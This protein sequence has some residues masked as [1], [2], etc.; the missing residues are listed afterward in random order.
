M[1]YNILKFKLIGI[2]GFLWSAKWSQSH[3]MYAPTSTAI[4][5]NI[6]HD[7]LVQFEMLNNLKTQITL[8]KLQAHL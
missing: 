8:E 7:T 4:F 2:Q 5:S 3:F 1:F 6:V